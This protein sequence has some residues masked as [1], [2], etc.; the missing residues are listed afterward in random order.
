MSRF[1]LVRAALDRLDHSNDD[2]WMPDGTPRLDAL[3]HLE[4]LPTREEINKFSVTR[5]KPEPTPDVV[6]SAPPM[7]ALTPD[8][9]RAAII[10]AENTLFVARQDVHRLAAKQKVDRAAASEAIENFRALWPRMTPEQN[11]RQFIASSI[12]QRAEI[13]AQTQAPGPDVIQQQA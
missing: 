8:E 7:P 2:H 5:R 3:V 11:A 13:A 9:A 10:E 6:E 4:P 1:D 12:E